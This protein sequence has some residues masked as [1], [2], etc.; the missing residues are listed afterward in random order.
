MHLLEIY[1]NAVGWVSNPPNR[2]TGRNKFSG[3]LKSFCTTMFRNDEFPAREV[4]SGSLKNN[5]SIIL[6]NLS[7][8]KAGHNHCS[9]L[10]ANCSLPIVLY[11]MRI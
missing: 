9:L 1:R 7:C 6:K 10:I 4:L 8:H 5:R 11:F 2:L 3:C